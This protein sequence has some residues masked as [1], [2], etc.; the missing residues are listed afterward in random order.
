MTNKPKNGQY[1][2]EDDTSAQIGIE[3]EED[4]WATA[5][6]PEPDEPEPGEQE[7]HLASVADLPHGHGDA[8]VATMLLG[9]MESRNLDPTLRLR[10]I[11]STGIC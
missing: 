10:P 7:P 8:T 1:E 3:A 4:I 5:V 2:H 11:R 6:A 9:R